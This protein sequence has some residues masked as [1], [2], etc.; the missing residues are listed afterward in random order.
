MK[1]FEFSLFNCEAHSLSYHIKETHSLIEDTFLG[2]LLYAH[3]PVP[4]IEQRARHTYALR[5]LMVQDGLTQN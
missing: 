1:E 5:E 4:G 2:H 3:R